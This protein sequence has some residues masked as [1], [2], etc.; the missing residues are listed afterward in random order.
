MEYNTTKPECFA[1][2]IPNVQQD[3]DFLSALYSYE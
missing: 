3:T 1:A 2:E